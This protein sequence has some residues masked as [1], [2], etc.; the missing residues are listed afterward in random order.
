MISHT[1]CLLNP[2][3]WVMGYLQV[4]G[5]RT[6]A[7][8]FAAPGQ[9]LFYQEEIRKWVFIRSCRT[10]IHE[11]PNASA[12]GVAKSNQLA[13]CSSIYHNLQQQNSRVNLRFKRFHTCQPGVFCML[14]PKF[15]HVFLQPHMKIQTAC[16]KPGEYHEKAF[17]PS[18]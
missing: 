2:L 12:R 6:F 18:C 13:L 10:G 14:V 16:S 11:L 5:S 1:F 15:Q 9:R 17:A 7:K 4:T 8:R 3:K